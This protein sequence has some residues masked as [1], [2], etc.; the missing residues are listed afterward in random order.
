MNYKFT[1][2]RTKTAV[3]LKIAAAQFVLAPEEKIYLNI[4]KT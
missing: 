2:D 3:P 1:L 4:V